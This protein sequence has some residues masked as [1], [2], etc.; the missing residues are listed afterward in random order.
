MYGHA[1]IHTCHRDQRV[2]IGRNTLH[3]VVNSQRM[4]DWWLEEKDISNRG[5]GVTLG[6]EFYATGMLKHGQ[7][8]N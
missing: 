7:W 3:C 8:D 2:G 4:I 5:E 1:L 6:K